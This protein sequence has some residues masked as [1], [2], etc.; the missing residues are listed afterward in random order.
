[1][2]HDKLNALRERSCERWSCGIGCVKTALFE[3]EI[4]RTGRRARSY[5]KKRRLCGGDQ[6]SAPPNLRGRVSEKENGVSCSTF[7]PL[8][9]FKS[10]V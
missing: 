7:W 6:C 5:E 8:W 10:N 1:M 9:Q 4:Y 2:P 3:D